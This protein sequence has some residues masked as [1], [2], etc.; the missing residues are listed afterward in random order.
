MTSPRVVRGLPQPGRTLVM[1]VVNVTPD[2]F[3]D[4]GEWFDPRAAAAHGRALLDQGA[5]LVDV[6]GES[7]RPGAERPSVAE[8]LRRVLPV[9]AALSEAGA[10][11]SI[12]TMRA[13]VAAQAVAAGARLV[14]DVSGGRAEP[15]ILDLVA[16][17]EVPYV[18]MHWRGHSARM[19]NR[20]SYADVAGEVADELAEQVRAARSAGISADR[21]VLDPGFGFAKTGDHNWTLLAQL[22]RLEDLGLPVLVGLSRKAFLGTLLA[23]P[24]GVARPAR[25]RDDATTALTTLLAQRQVWGVRVHSVRAS[26]DAVAVV[27]RLAAEGAVR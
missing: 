21:L 7:T 20:A 4:G 27:E 23:D 22:P 25:G 12:D 13:E 19:Q 14:N 26:R 1:G 11:V 6:G 8:E 10:C 3:S 16:A 17:L 18:C 5:D 9:V 15:E 24:D 2:S